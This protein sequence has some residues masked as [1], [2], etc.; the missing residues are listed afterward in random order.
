[1]AVGAERVCPHL[2]LLLLA[3][4]QLTYAMAFK[5]VFKSQGLVHPDHLRIFAVAFVAG[6][7]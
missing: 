5:T 2:G 4:L 7:R 1:M 3:L 6:S